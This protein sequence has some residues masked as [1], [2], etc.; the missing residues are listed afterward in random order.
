VALVGWADG[1]GERFGIY[2]GQYDGDGMHGL[3]AFETGLRRLLGDAEGRAHLGAAGR[4]WVMREH[5]TS[6]FIGS[7]QK[8][9]VRAGVARGGWIARD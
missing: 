8:I 9:A 7:Y 6:R 4:D 1:V 2:T 3:P 5:N